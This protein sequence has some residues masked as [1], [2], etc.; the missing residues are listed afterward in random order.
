M[1]FAPSVGFLVRPDEMGGSGIWASFSGHFGGL[2]LCVEGW[3]CFVDA[4]WVE[5]IGSMNTGAHLGF[6]LNQDRFRGPMN[7]EPLWV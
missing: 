4:E 7:L 6:V 2:V 3:W 1:L 5:W